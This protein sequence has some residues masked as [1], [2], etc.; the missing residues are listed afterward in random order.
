MSNKACPICGDK[1]Y[2]LT[3]NGICPSCEIN[4]LTFVKNRMSEAETHRQAALH[5]TSPESALKEWEYCDQI[6]QSIQ[7]RYQSAQIDP[8]YIYN[9]NITL[10]SVR[11]D[12]QS[13]INFYKKQIM[14]SIPESKSAPSSEPFLFCPHCGKPLSEKFSFCPFCGK[15]LSSSLIKQNPAPTGDVT[16]TAKTVSDS[17]YSA[18]WE[19][20]SEMPQK[21]T[22]SY[23]STEIKTPKNKHRITVFVL[24]L[25]VFISVIALSINNP[26]NKQ[27]AT[28]QSYSE[29][30]N[31]ATSQTST[32][33]QIEKGD[34]NDSDNLITY[35][36]YTKIETGMTYDEVVEIIGS[37]GYELSRVDIAGYQTVSVGWDGHG[38]IGTNAN[39]T[40]QNG[41]VVSKAQAGLK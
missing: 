17:S 13:K 39:V 27:P 25:V 32:Q 22:Y 33:E 40:F 24:F 20:S 12:C 23:Q 3:S 35:E 16:V 41:V 14:D 29:T 8:F 37:Y 28:N 30:Q 15:Q 26:N 11:D 18:S 34:S 9:N 36:E 10:R 19:N 1:N 6:Y 31:H 21:E 7:E 4:L 5:A 38:S 2:Q